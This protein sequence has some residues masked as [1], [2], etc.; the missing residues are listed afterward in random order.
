MAKY[1]GNGYAPS[2]HLTCPCTFREYN[3]LYKP[4]IFK[5]S[6]DFV[7]IELKG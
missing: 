4:I 3:A 7:I 1:N 2:L 6:L 5:A